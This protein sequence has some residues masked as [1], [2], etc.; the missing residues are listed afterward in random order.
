MPITAQAIAPLLQVIVSVFAAPVIDGTIGPVLVP[1]AGTMWPERYRRYDGTAAEVR[2]AMIADGFDA[3]DEEVLHVYRLL[4]NPSPVT[5]VLVG[6][7]APVDATWEAALAAI[8]QAIEDAGEATPAYLSPVTRAEDEQIELF[9]AATDNGRDMLPVIQTASEA[10]RDNALGSLEKVLKAVN[11]QGVILYYDAATATGAD[12]ASAATSE[13]PW[14]IPL[15]TTTSPPSASAS[16][17]FDDAPGV[18]ATLEAAP[19]TVTGSNAEP[20]N[21]EPAWHLDY[22][23]D[24][25]ADPVVLT[26]AAT[27]AQITGTAIDGTSG[28]AD[29]VLADGMPVAMVVRGTP[30]NYNVD[31]ANYVDVTSATAAEVAAEMDTALAALADAAAV[32]GQVRATDKVR[33][34]QSEIA[35]V[36]GTSAAFASAIGV[37]IGQAAHGDGNVGNVDAVTV[38]ELAAIATTETGDTLSLTEDGSAPAKVKLSGVIFGTGGNLDLLGSSTAGLLTALGLAAGNSAGSGDCA[39]SRAVTPAELFAVLDTGWAAA[40]VVNDAPAATVTVSG[41]EIGSPHYMLIQGPLAEA[42]GLEGTHLA[43]GSDDEH[44]DAAWL[45]SRAG[46]NHDS[47]PP[48]GGILA[49]NNVALRGVTGEKKGFLSTGDRLNRT[50]DVNY[51]IRWTPARGGEAHDGRLL[52]RHEGGASAYADQWEAAHWIAKF[53]AGTIKAALDQIVSSGNQVPYQDPAIRSFVLSQLQPIAV[54]LFGNQIV[55]AVDL[56]P[57]G[58]S[59]VTGLTVLRKDQLSGTDRDLRYF[60]AIWTVELSGALHGGI[61]QIGLLV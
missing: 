35:F 11:K 40:D 48:F 41:G 37:T 23:R 13:G 42:V 34:N 56:D 1:V 49:W 4:D 45:G 33:G 19:G 44:A 18:V 52:I 61:V 25:A 3:F 6:R 32:G 28:G 39:D 38:A 51:V 17:A 24:F 47:P 10:V 12:V 8:L 43:P 60:K 16:L 31:A 22:V 55:A 14:A 15:D 7:R 30:V 58:P 53:T 9:K 29:F 59:K 50:Q 20:F 36:A 5:F 27:A 2:E 46:I 57:P 21:L 26:I 54:R